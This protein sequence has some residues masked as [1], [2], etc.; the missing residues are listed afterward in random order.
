MAGGERERDD[1]FWSLCKIA[2]DRMRPEIPYNKL[3][4]PPLVGSCSLFSRALFR[5]E[6]VLNRFSMS[7]VGG[8]K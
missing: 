6:E 2:A 1:L 3:G 5:V 7:R 4:W 8:D